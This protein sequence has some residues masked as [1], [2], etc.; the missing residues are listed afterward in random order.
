MPLNPQDVAAAG[1]A[2]LAKLTES[3]DV[4]AGLTAANTRAAI[5]RH[6]ASVTG[7]PVTEADVSAIAD[8][9]N[10]NRSA[11]CEQLAMQYPAVGSVIEGSS[12]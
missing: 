11:E 8:F 10:A 7:M 9:L 4:R 1:D 2:Y 5:A 3:A 6:V 12:D